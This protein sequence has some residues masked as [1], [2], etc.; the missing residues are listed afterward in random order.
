MGMAVATAV[1]CRRFRADILHAN[2]LRAGTAAVMAGAL[3]APGAVV[4]VRDVLPSTRAARTTARFVA[5]RAA[6]TIAISSYV[7][8]SFAELAGTL[9]PRVILNSVDLR[10]FD[11]SRFSQ[12]RARARLGFDVKVPLLGVIGQITPWKGQDDAVRALATV[13]REHPTARL[14]IVGSPKFVSSATRFDNLTFE[15]RLRSLVAE[16][17]L[18]DAVSCLGEREDIPEVISA[19]DVALAPSWE[20]PFGRAVV[21]AM[22][23]GVPVVATSCGGP[24]EIVTD[25]VD[26][27][28]APPRQP[29]RWAAAISGLLSDPAARDRIGTRARETVE[30]RFHSRRLGLELVGVYQELLGCVR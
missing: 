16:L 19:L 13:R 20:E 30:A 23:M 25:G 9:A 10:R 29:D 15:R 12:A 11:P 4:H 2:S 24:A 18:G 14:L 1:H 28:L 7:A 27:V 8:G 5:S 6:A 21:E 3:G 17:G 22:A 26:G